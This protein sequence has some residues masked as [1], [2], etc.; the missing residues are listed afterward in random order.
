M[1][2]RASVAVIMSV[3]RS[4][5]PQMLQD[6]VESILNQTVLCDLLIYQDG[7]VPEKLSNLLKKYK[8]RNNIKLFINPINKGLAHGLNYL[9]NE[10]LD[11]RYD[12]IARMDSDDISR[13]SRIEQ[14]VKFL[15]EN[16][17][18]DVLGTSCR[19]FGA[20]FALEEKHLPKFHEE[21][22][23]FSITRCPLI[24]P[25][26]MF[27]SSVFKNGIRYPENTTLTEDMALWFLLL[28]KGY[29]F[30]NLNEILLDY[31]LNE[32]T[33]NR[34]KG[35]SKAMSEIDIR[36]RNMISL[37]QV[38]LKNISLIGAR[39]IFHLMPGPLI[40]LAYKKAR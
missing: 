31:R 7:D 11:K 2:A 13:E 25:S 37:K 4:D 19:E 38:N 23:N 22:I 28:N 27:R 20:S 24:H 17:D 3:Y 29:R 5:D 39:I 16:L 18:I 10:S 8:D 34:R 30:A 33:I 1:N 6:A 9:I 40:K 26:V 35:F 15:N 32:G 21:L 14:Q 36:I 12:Y